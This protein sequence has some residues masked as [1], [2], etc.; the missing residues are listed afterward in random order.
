LSSSRLITIE[1]ATSYHELISLRTP[2]VLHIYTGGFASPT[3]ITLLQAIRVAQPALP[4][5]H[6]G[7]LDAGG[8]RILLHL[9]KQLGEVR[10]LA[11]NEATFTLFQDFAQHLTAN[12]RVGLTVLRANDKLQDCADIIGTLLADD[13]K[14]EQEAV[15]PRH[16]IGLLD[17]LQIG[18]QDEFTPTD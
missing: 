4:F 9:R 10:P 13:H 5:Y 7:D 14:L 11:M 12:D 17:K 16:A 8:F 15:E 1:N 18:R 6:W 2:D 3:V